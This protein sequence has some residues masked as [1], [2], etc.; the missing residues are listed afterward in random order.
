MVHNKAFSS[1]I[2]NCIIIYWVFRFGI[3]TYINYLNSRSTGGNYE[4][5]IRIPHFF[6]NRSINIIMYRSHNTNPMASRIVSHT[7]NLANVIMSAFWL[8]VCFLW[9]FFICL[10]ICLFVRWFEKHSKSFKLHAE[11][12]HCRTFLLWQRATTTYKLENLNQIFSS[13]RSD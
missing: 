12:K 1:L 9:L 2:C 7:L 6:L 4:L 3:T 11:R 5:L 13:L 10:F 8:F